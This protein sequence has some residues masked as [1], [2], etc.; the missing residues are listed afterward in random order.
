MGKSI[1]ES[2]IA[3]IGYGALGVQI[4]NYLIE[5]G[6][7]Q[8]NFIYFDDI[9]FEKKVINTFPFNYYQN[10]QFNEYQWI[11]SLG[12]KNLSLKVEIL[13]WLKDQNRILHSFTHPTAYIHP[14]VQICDG[15]VIYPGCV[16]DQNVIIG[17]GALLN[18]GVIVSHNSKIGPGCFIAPGVCISGNVSIGE[19]CFLGTG[20]IVSNNIKISDSCI[21]GIGSVV[22]KDLP[23]R[24]YA[25]GNPLIIR[26]SKLN[27]P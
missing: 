14:T 25:I 2:K 10:D 6:Y 16:I 22:T 11:V 21:L 20:T 17:A 19:K 4:E 8:P 18:C 12:Y 1:S 9:A 15:A 27:I 26:K 5:A 23:K 13:S 3:F 7:N 24:T